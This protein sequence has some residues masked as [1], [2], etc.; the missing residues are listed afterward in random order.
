MVAAMKYQV[1]HLSTFHYGK[2]VD[3]AAH[4]LRL[5]PRP[6]PWQ[7]VLASEIVT[8]P[9]PARLARGA[10]YFGNGLTFLDVDERHDV[11]A[12]ELRSTVEVAFPPPPD[13]ASTPPWEAVRDR[14]REGGGAVL[15]DAA[16]FTYDSPLAAP[17]AAIED[18]AAA[19]FRPGRPMLDAVRDL[20]R[21]IHRD[22]AF[23]PAATV[24]ATPLAEVMELRRGV[25]QDF[26]HL[27]LAA[28]RAMGLP[29]RYVSGYIR[30]YAADGGP[31]LAGADAS[32]AWVSVFCPGAGWVDFDPTN[33]LIVGDEHIVLAWGRDYGDVSPIRGVLL[34]GGEHSL[35]VAVDVMPAA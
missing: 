14:L 4:V 19:S 27:Q 8:D 24:I 12:V 16:E 11:F 15:L 31:N 3:L 13:A 30:T 1:R 21:R 18:Y 10:D 33:D 6:L 25:C 7:R 9:Q 26:A 34:G 32:H 20:T 5:S 2:P 22:F 28:M 29:A 17:D 35:E 23:D